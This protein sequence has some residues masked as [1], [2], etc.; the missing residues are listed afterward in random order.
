MAEK[1]AIRDAY[2]NALVKIGGIQENI[3][4]LEAD[5]GSSTKSILFG[6]KYPE[7]YFNVGIS[8]INMV[9]MA[10]G[11]ALSGF[12]TFVNTFSVF[13]TTRGLDPINSLI[14]YDSLN[15]K[16]IGNYSGLSDSYDGA[17][18]QAVFDIACMRS[19]P[20][21]AIIS[22]CDQIET[23][24]AVLACGEYNG[25]VYMRLSRNANPI[26]YDTCYNFELGKGVVIKEGTDITIIATGYMVQ[27][28]LEAAEMLEER[29]ICAK[30]V[31]IHT[32]KPLDEELI[33]NCAKQTG[34]VLT[35]EEHSVYG[36]LGSA[37]SEVLS[38]HYPVPVHIM[39][40]TGYAE[41]GDYEKL[42]TK[43]SLDANAIYQRVQKIMKQNKSYKLI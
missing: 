18:H 38:Q 16:L 43:Y 35:V 31:N 32:I 3:V 23:E 21:M 10:S 42:L 2:G 7:R 5:V 17:S 40:L 6:R 30:I 33:I 12:N 24:K 9:A 4:V 11:F 28:A 20:N 8:E 15:V 19:L 25:P 37:V 39:G 29:S 34:M 26:V 22:P 27:K 36:G 13:M 1:I 41:S 14:A